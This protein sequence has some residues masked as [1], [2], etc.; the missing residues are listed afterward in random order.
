M[1]IDIIN[2]LSIVA[3]I[4]FMASCS[5]ESPTP[6]V[7]T[8][9]V[10]DKEEVVEKYT[11]YTYYSYESQ[12]ELTASNLK[13]DS[14]GETF[15]PYTIACLGD[16]L[17]VSNNGG[18]SYSFVAYS[19]SKK[20]VLKKIERFT[21]GGNDTTFI[22]QIEAIVPY[23]GK[24][25][26][27]ERQSRIHVFSLPDLEYITCIGNGNW[28]AQVFQSQALIIKDGIIYSR[29]K[30]SEV[31]LYK[32]SEATAENY[33]KINRWKKAAGI[34]SA[35]NGFCA[36]GMAMLENGNILLT[37]YVA[38]LIRV[39]DT[40]K[41]ETFKNGESIDIDDQKIETSFN[42]YSITL[43]KDKMYLTGADGKIHPYDRTRK[44]WDTEI[45]NVKGHEFA[46]PQ[47]VYALDD[48]TLYVSDKGALVKVSIFKQ[49]LR[50]YED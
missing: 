30:N 36:H 20:S 21:A 45:S 42:P 46:S 13:F 9:E 12:E 49:E 43:T 18:N 10:P 35:N 1:K 24:L 32:T 17:F 23:D 5:S 7:T 16:T 11:T 47:K 38:K 2:R 4:A 14:A 19:M 48:S 3:M 31:S 44:E 29:D 39:L 15:T 37:D 22:S 28:A 27:A 26:V 34:S 50:E 41:T 33:Q 25:Y 40:S 8:P 6:N